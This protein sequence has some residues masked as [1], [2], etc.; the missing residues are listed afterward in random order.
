M[1]GMGMERSPFVVDPGMG[2]LQDLNILDTMPDSRFDRITRIALRLFQVPI[3]AVSVLNGEQQWVKSCQGLSQSQMTQ[4]PSFC[5]H[6]IEAKDVLCIAS[7]LEDARVANHPLV[8]GEPHVRFYAGYPLGSDNAGVGALYIMDYQPRI[9]SDDEI[10]LL[11]DL[12]SWAHMELI[13]IRE[14]EWLIDRKTKELVHSEEAFFRIL[15]SLP[16]GVFVLKP[17]GKPFYANQ[18]AQQILG[19]GIIEG[20]EPDRIPETYKAYVAGTIREY[21]ADRLPI[22]RALEGISTEVEDIDIHRPDGILSVQ[23]WGTPV[24]HKGKIVYAVAAFQD[25]TQRKRTERRMA[26][27][28]AVTDLLSHDSKVP[29]AAS[30]ILKTIG[31]HLKWDLGLLW[32]VDRAANV[33]RCVHAWHSPSA[34]VADFVSLSM[35][36]QFEPSIGLPGRV[37]TD[38]KPHWIADVSEDPNFPRTPA[39]LKNGLRSALGIPIRFGEEIT[40]VLEYFSLSVQQPDKDLLSTLASLASQ[41]GPL[42]A[43]NAP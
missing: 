36:L 39:A 38:R 8:A 40:G 35:K 14:L 6:T 25:I 2:T 42:L 33:L 12:G 28:R 32:K 4:D 43:G 5:K 41:V 27:E 26:V 24:Y 23:V 37:W 9:L 17:D 10:Q 22:V 30:E 34:N 15:D 1:T 3:A 7:T 13:R 29:E 16:V 19:K 21:P 20:S 31:E 11:R 18:S